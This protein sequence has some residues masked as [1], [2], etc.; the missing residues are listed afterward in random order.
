MLDDVA[1]EHPVAGIISDE[2]DLGIL[3]W[4]QQQRI[5]VMRWL[6]LNA[7]SQ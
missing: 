5:G 7:R 1:M 6:L 3:V 4:Q 2:G